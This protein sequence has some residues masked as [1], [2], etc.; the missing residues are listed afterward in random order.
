MPAR[1]YDLLGIGDCESESDLPAG[2]WLYP[3]VNLPMTTFQEAATY[4]LNVAG[5]T[6]IQLFALGGP[7]LLLIALLS[8]LSGWVQ[9]L[10][11]AAFGITT[12]LLLFGWLGTAIH[13]TGHLLAALLFRHQVASF[14]PFAPN[15]KTGVLGSVGTRYHAGNL[16][17]YFGLFFIG[18]APVVFGTLAIYLALYGL[19]HGQMTE[20]WRVI[21]RR[22][23]IYGPSVGNILSSGLAFLGFVFSPRHLLDWR[24][25]LFLYIAFSVGS[26]IHL[27]DS[28][29]AGAA[30]GCLP[31]IVLLFLFNTVLLSLGSA[32]SA[33]FAWLTQYY[34]FLYILLCFVILLNVLAIAV[35]WLP[36]ML[37][38]H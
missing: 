37:R 8:W 23:T 10:A 18:I 29:K 34:T 9:R 33:T 22:N 7:V 30:T 5:I 20:V 2:D 3:K 17:Q 28:D 4:L 1:W 25:Y 35:L 19:F 15:L 13:E 31:M 36:A 12:Y 21:D 27:S 16:Y 11:I 6:L 38:A 32:G 26:S 14:R 24:L